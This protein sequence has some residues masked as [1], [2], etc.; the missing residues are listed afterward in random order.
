[1][2]SLVSKPLWMGTLP[3][4]SIVQHSFALVL[5]IK[6]HIHRIQSVQQLPTHSCIP[7]L[8]YCRHDWYPSAVSMITFSNH[9]LTYKFKLQKFYLVL[10]QVTKYVTNAGS[11]HCTCCKCYLHNPP[12]KED[13]ATERYET[14]SE[15]FYMTKA[16]L[17]IGHK[18]ICSAKKV[19]QSIPV[20]L[21]A[22]CTPSPMYISTR[23]IEGLVFQPTSPLQIGLGF[24]QSHLCD[25]SGIVGL[26]FIFHYSL[27][28]NCGKGGTR[29]Y[30]LC[31]PRCIH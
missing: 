10:S 28:N 19:Q 8:R 22:I 24:I 1:M 31:S 14:M 11:L 26:Q 5:G 9:E 13:I 4:Y 29:G 17:V 30:N 18:L 20:L 16:N 23:L 6:D 2:D 27:H 15:S 25:L 3:V 7:H 12:K 21:T